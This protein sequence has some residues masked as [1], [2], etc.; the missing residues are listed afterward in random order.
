MTG[1]RQ[2]GERGENLNV[3]L[4]RRER[5]GSSALLPPWNLDDYCCRSGGMGSGI[6]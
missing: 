4:M 1:K 5:K 6:V 3:K 2:I